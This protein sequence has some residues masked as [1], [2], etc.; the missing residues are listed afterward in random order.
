MGTTSTSGWALFWLFLG[1]ML[2]CASRTG[3]GPLSLLGGI[4][5]IVVS[6]VLFQ[7]ARGKEEEA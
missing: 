5:L 2:V 7:A 4:A 6:C 3:G 1:I